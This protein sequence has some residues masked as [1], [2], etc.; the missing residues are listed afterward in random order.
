MPIDVYKSRVAMYLTNHVTGG[1]ESLLCVDESSVKA[2]DM[3][4]GAALM[5]FARNYC[6]AFCL[7][8]WGRPFV[9][10]DWEFDREVRALSINIYHRR[11]PY[12][13]NREV[14]YSK[15]TLV[16]TIRLSDIPDSKAYEAYA[17]NVY[18]D[19]VDKY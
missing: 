6:S 8:T 15:F 19:L 16:A 1:P 7:N 11:I 4:N 3:V 5:E 9:Y 14:D 12:A 13:E 10:N 18:A 2:C 17:K